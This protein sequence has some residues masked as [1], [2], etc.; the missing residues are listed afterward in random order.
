MVER[1][2]ERVA[3]VSEIVSAPSLHVWFTDPTYQH[4]MEHERN[5][6]ILVVT[7]VVTVLVSQSVSGIIIFRAERLRDMRYQ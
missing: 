7:C 6:N 5:L 4:V 1:G 3:L 2:E